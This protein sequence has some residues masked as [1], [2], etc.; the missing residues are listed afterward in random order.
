MEN[1]TAV[2]NF[3]IVEAP[4][5]IIVIK[6]LKFMNDKYSPTRINT[7]DGCKLKYKYQYIDKLESDL[8][9]IERFMGSMVHEV[10][11]EFYKLV[12]NGSV[13]PLEW[14]LDKYKEVWQKNYTE[15][16]K[17]VKEEISAE[18]Y[19]NKGKQCL[20]DYYEKYKPFDQ[21]KIVDTEH[22]VSFNVEFDKTECQFC[23]VLDRLDWNDKED[24]FEIHDY[25]VTNSLMTQ[26]KADNDWQLGLYHIAL[27]E[28]WPEIEKIKL[29]WHSL[30]FNKEIISFRTKEQIGQLKKQVIERVKE[31]ENCDKF[32]PGKS[33]LCDWC[34]FQN[35]CPLWKHPKEMEEL[36]IN[37]YKKDPGVKLVSEYKK[38]EE[39]KNE[40]KEEIYKI[41]EEQEKIKEAAVEFAEREKISIIDGPDA[42][43]K[44]DIKDELRAPIRAEDQ[45]SWEK[46]RDLLIQEQ[47]YQEVSTV[48][49]NMLNY[50]IRSNIWPSDFIK[51][52]EQF[53]KHQIT[54]T[55]RLVKK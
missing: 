11:E 20:E 46:L 31:I 16:I 50:R 45:V 38:L 17:I 4:D 42:R 49:G 37:E 8:T 27:K 12:K 19:Y 14:V 3:L 5:P 43:L 18:D 34:D 32:P 51:K 25:K 10:L 28:K 36:E 55:V 53:L 15:S 44:V 47:K 35:I 26:E 6:F 22:F 24:I 2:L 54:K 52:I 21:S 48:N 9:T 30:L 29:V 39:A 23:G 40:F 33:V 13:K 7:F 1:F 41:E